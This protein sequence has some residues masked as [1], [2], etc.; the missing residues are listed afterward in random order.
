ML[1][2]RSSMRGEVSQ[3]QCYIDA[4]LDHNFS[5]IHVSVLKVMNAVSEDGRRD[6][7]FGVS[8]P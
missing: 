7:M 2:V 5:M 1:I 4:N 3:K 6:V 8:K